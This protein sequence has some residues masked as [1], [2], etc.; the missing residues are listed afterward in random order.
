[1]VSD[2]YLGETLGI[3]IL[4]KFVFLD[5]F[6]W[7]EGNTQTDPPSLSREMS[8]WGMIYEDMFI[9]YLVS[10]NQKEDWKSSVT[11]TKACANEETG[12]GESQ[13]LFNVQ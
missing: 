8:F 11:G 13:T 1:M 9:D 3:S 5:E 4:E 6:K 7:R 2:H 10:T 12:L